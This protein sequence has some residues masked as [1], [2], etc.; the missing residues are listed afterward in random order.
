M[1]NLLLTYILGKSPL[2]RTEYILT[3]YRAMIHICF[4]LYEVTILMLLPGLKHHGI[5]RQYV[6][7]VVNLIPAA[8]ASTKQKKT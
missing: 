1:D 2:Y 5:L 4:C 8:V 3:P 7:R 6:T